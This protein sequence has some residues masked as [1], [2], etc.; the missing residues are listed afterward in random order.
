MA[1]LSP[2]TIIETWDAGRR[3]HPI[4]RALMLVSVARE[5]APE[6]LPDLPL[7]EVNRVLMDLRRMC[8]GDKLEMWADCAAC[9]KRMSLQIAADE[10]PASSA[11]APEVQVRGHRFRRPTSRDLAALV[12]APDVEAAALRLCRACAVDPRT[13]PEGEALD[14]FLREVEAALDEADPWADPTLV[15]ACPSCGHREGIALDVAGILWD[16]IAAVAERLIDHVHTIASAYGWSER[17][18]LGMSEARRVAYIARV[19]S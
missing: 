3:R 13:L 5:V 10:L 9:G 11:V 4:D 1:M 7:G 14:V 16:E 12:G 15:S 17:E 6:A 19:V 8:F 2:L 18:I